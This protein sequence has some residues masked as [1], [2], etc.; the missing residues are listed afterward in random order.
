MNKT[1]R[2][3]FCEWL[4]LLP[5]KDFIFHSI[6]SFSGAYFADP[7][8]VLIRGFVASYGVGTSIT[9]SFAELLQKEDTNLSNNNN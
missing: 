9:T 6:A 8:D 7:M 4:T 2:A 5:G 1:T 3:Y